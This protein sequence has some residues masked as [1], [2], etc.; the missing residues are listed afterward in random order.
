MSFLALFPYVGILFLVIIN[1]VLVIKREIKV[2]RNNDDG[3]CF[4]LKILLK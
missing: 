2:D 1:A 3:Q 4:C